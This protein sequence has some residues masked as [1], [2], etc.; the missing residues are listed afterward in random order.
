L[1]LFIN[2]ATVIIL[3]YLLGS[4]P[5]AFVL[6]KFL[7]GLTIMRE[8]S[9]NVGTLNFFRVTR[10]KIASLMV[11]GLDLLKGYLAVFLT[12]VYFGSEYLLPASMAVIVGHIFPVWTS[13]KGGRGLATLAGIFLY[14]EPLV[15]GG[16]WLIFGVLYFLMRKYILAGM[17]ALFLVNVLTFIFFDPHLFS[18][19]SVNSIM[20]MLK[21]RLRI[22]QEIQNKSA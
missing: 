17:I 22:V 8:G 4:F 21:Y 18:I 5:S 13:G 12:A 1:P 20:V 14:L 10:A 11:L 3:A 16:W 2:I 6:G 15:F 9:G 19:L 7:Y